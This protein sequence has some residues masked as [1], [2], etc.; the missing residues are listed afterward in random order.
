MMHQ[1]LARGS[2]RSTVGSDYRV[3]IETIDT[4]S[5]TALYFCKDYL[6]REEYLMHK[7]KERRGVQ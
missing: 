6:F 7:R 5:N 1:H 2:Y 3:D 4:Y